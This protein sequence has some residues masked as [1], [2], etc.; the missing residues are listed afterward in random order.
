M[1]AGEN[2]G[3]NIEFAIGEG[4]V[5]QAA[6]EKRS[7]EI[8]SSTQLQIPAG[9]GVVRPERLLLVPVVNTGISTGVIELAPASSL[10]DEQRAL[11]EALLPTV[12]LNLEILMGN[13]ATRKLLEQTKAQAATVA[14]AE[15]RF[16]LILGSVDEGILGMDTNGVMS[17]INQAGAQMVGYEPH[18]LVGHQMHARLHYAHEDGTVFPREE[19]SMYK[20][21]HDGQSREVDN[22]VL[23]R[24]DGTCFP[25]EYSTTAVQKDGETVGTVV[26]F[27]DISERKAAEARL[28]FTQYAVDNAADSVYWVRASDGKLEYVNNAAANILGYTQEELLS[29]SIG[30]VVEGFKSEK[31]EELLAKL[32]ETPAVTSET[33]LAAKEGPAID[34]ETTISIADYL[35]RKIL[36]TNVR[37][38]T[39]RKQA[40]AAIH[41]AREIAEAATKAKSDFLA[42]MSHEIR[43]PMNAIIGLNHLALKTELTR[44]QRDYLTKVNSAAQALLGIINDILDFSKIEAG[45]LDMEKTR[46]P[47][48]RT[49]RQ[50]NFYRQ[51][52]S[53]RQES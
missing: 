42:N 31:W 23:W 15:E 2:D 11:L 20:T 9:L 27:R 40:E 41:H 49:A 34:V 10:N 50:R 1:F 7:L 45:K 26:A 12:A 18:E 19:C 52:K 16:R 24:R 17:F 47:A 46:I 30:D 43:T 35:G 48:G 36:I 29:M 38:I 39:E 4:L 51:P 14:A 22:E 44:K 8:P 3:K 53:A 32:R 33:K 5:G 21:A 6:A 28:K 13:L 37:D 25:V